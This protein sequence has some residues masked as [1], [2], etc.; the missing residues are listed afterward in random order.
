MIYAHDGWCAINQLG[1]LGVGRLIINAT[2]ETA[3]PD[4]QG[5]VLIKR[6]R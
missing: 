6:R 1:N 4:T 2:L 5:V 3:Q